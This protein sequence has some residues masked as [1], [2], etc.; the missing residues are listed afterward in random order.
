MLRADQYELK[1]ITT[2]EELHREYQSLTPPGQWKGWI[3]RGERSDR[4]DL[5]TSL[6]REMKSFDVPLANKARMTEYNLLRQFKR[7]LHHYTTDVPNKH[8]TVEWLA[9]MQHYGAPTR[10]LDWTY[11]FWVAVY[12]AIE[13]A[14]EDECRVWALKLDAFDRE[15]LSKGTLKSENKLV[16]EFYTKLRVMM[17]DSLMDEP[18]LKQS[19]IVEY[20]LSHPRPLVF[21]VN[22][23]RQNERLTIQQGVF[24][25]P[26]DVSKSFECNLTA[27]RNLQDK[28]KKI[29]IKCNSEIRKNVLLN[30]YRMNINRASLFP[31][32][33]GFAESLRTRLALPELMRGFSSKR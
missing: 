8:D 12:F 3:Y 13:S 19:A 18:W 2:W 24:L 17:K 14:T 5:S 25:M 22:S 20:L 32:L 23:F 11:S 10:L 21:S 31:G 7:R 27:H 30:L 4:Y 6:E 15:A 33:T 16:K 26:G 1:T 9:L 28:L 29:K